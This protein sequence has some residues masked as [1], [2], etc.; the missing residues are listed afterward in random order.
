MEGWAFA[1]SLPTNKE[2]ISRPLFFFLLVRSVRAGSGGA[3]LGDT[4]GRQQD[5][6][7]QAEMTAAGWEWEN[8]N[9]SEWVFAPV[10]IGN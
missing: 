8:E 2:R 6:Y 7:T 9:E 5:R 1:G 10:V 3:P 4:S